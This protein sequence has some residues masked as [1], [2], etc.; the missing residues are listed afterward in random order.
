MLWPVVPLSKGQLLDVNPNDILNGGLYRKCS[1]YRGG[2]GYDQFPLICERR[3]GQK[4]SEQ[5]VVQLQKC[6]LDCPYCYVTREGVWGKPKYIGTKQLVD[7]FIA[8]GQEVFHLMG[9][10]PVIYIDDWPELINAVLHNKPGTVFHS[11][12]MLIEGSYKK[13]T[14]EKL[15][16]SH[17][18]F[19]VNIKGTDS[20]TWF[21]NTRRTPQWS[22]FWNNWRKV[23]TVG[24][25]YYTTF[26]NASTVQI[27]RFWE[28]ARRNGI[29]RDQDSYAIDLID[30]EAI[31]H[32]DD[33]KWGLI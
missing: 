15:R 33:V 18:L 26:T 21:K 16:Y 2:G 4:L 29:Y 25:P 23:Q 32:V 8:S 6:T 7:D 3:L 5:F 27:R 1:T 13:E 12:L 14:L 10:A 20:S 28:L 17:C 30:Y 19:A 11:D 31:P 9:G 24:V 22:L